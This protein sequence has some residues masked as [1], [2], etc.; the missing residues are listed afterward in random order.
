MLT[1]LHHN[2]KMKGINT[3]EGIIVTVYADATEDQGSPPSLSKR[4][5]DAVKKYLIERGMYPSRI[6]TQE[7]DGPG[8]RAIVE[9]DGKK[10][11]PLGSHGARRTARRRSRRYRRIDKKVSNTLYICRSRSFVGSKPRID[12]LPLRALLATRGDRECSG[13]GRVRFPLHG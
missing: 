5:A 6:C 7:H 10:E 8:Q 4:R 12:T 11:G 13:R 2:P 3:V 9:A 1:Y